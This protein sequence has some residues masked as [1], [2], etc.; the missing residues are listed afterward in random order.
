MAV[1][2]SRPRRENEFLRQERDILKR[3]TASFT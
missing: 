3:A 2:L 1:E